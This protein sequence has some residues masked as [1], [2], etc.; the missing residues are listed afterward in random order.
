VNWGEVTRGGATL[1]TNLERGPGHMKLSVP[2]RLEHLYLG[3]HTRVKKRRISQDHSKGKL[4]GPEGK[5]KQCWG[6]ERPSLSLY[7]WENGNAGGREG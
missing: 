2:V 5:E 6:R 4:Q 7:P 1:S 3:R